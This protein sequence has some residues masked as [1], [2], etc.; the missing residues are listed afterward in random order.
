MTDQHDPACPATE[1]VHN[2]TCPLHG[3]ASDHAVVAALDPETPAEPA[4][5]DPWALPEPL[6]WEHDHDGW[7]IVD[8]DVDGDGDAL[9][10][11]PVGAIRGSLTRR[12]DAARLIDLLC[13]R[14]AAEP[15]GPT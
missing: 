12:E 5:P 9:W 11:Q 4:A 2:P 1:R 8:G 3:E 6:V 14:H 7:Y 15:T 13:R 10:I